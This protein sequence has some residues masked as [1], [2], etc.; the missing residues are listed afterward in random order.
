M[1]PQH[2]ALFRAMAQTWYA[3]LSSGT[4]KSNNFQLHPPVNE[5]NNVFTNRCGNLAYPLL[6]SAEWNGQEYDSIYYNPRVLN[7]GRCG[8]A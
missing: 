6:L 1:R 2:D 5:N 7:T 8:R 3:Q 4:I